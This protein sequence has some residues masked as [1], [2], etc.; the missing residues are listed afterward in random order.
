MLGLL[1]CGPAFESRSIAELF[2]EQELINDIIH[3]IV[4]L[5]RDK[6]ISQ[7]QL[8]EI[9]NTTQPLI[10]RLEGMKDS[11]VPSLKLLSKLAKGLGKKI[12]ISFED[13]PDH[14]LATYK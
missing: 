6:N 10:S 4:Q 8:A 12:K 14:T 13:L 1:F 7:S 11:R 3:E 5:R 2:Q 9:T